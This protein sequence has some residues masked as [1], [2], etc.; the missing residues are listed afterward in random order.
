MF[1]NHPR[2]I[3]A[4]L[5]FLTDYRNKTDA[6]LDA[7]YLEAHPSSSCEH[8][9]EFNRLAREALGVNVY[10]Q[11]RR[12]ALFEHDAEPNAAERKR[13]RY[14]LAAWLDRHKP[15]TVCVIPN[16]VGGEVSRGN[17]LCWQHFGAPDSAGNMRGTFYEFA[18][19]QFVTPL[20]SYSS[21]AKQLTIHQQA[22]FIERAN[23]VA[24]DQEELLTCG[25]KVTTV[26]ED[27]WAAL[28]AMRNKP[29][30]VD[31]ESVESSGIIT[32]IG[33][34]DGDWAVSIPWHRF[35]PAGR[36]EP[37]I[38]LENY[39]VLGRTIRENLR[40]ILDD[41]TPKFFHNYTFDVPRLRE[42]G[43]EIAGAI[44][45]TMAAHAIA[46]PELRHGLQHACAD[47]LPIR[48]WKSIWHPKMKG[49]TRDDEEFWTCDPEALRDY[50]AD[51]AFH[52]YHLARAIMPCVG[53]KL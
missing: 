34:S 3:C 51:D 19:G 22:R 18:P 47:M 35:T 8:V 12:L 38:G 37:E 52:T 40:T 7:A 20:H 4:P 46:F 16:E 21:W 48:P 41:A 10:R 49:V 2:G 43:F 26:G 9:L 32:A 13:A 53:V 15:R 39:G 45:D 31:I 5:V 50:N 17:T 33:V 14:E 11:C 25:K 36:D 6:Q 42:E 24:S 23:R 27:M 29:V 1:R 30:A 44:H 28:I